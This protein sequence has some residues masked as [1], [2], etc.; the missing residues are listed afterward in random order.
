VQVPSVVMRYVKPRF[1]LRVNQGLADELSWAD[2]LQRG[3]SHDRLDSEVMPLEL[4]QTEG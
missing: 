3:I 2:T 1:N 4:L